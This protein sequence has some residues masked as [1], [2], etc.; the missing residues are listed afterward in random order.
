MK[1]INI[2][3]NSNSQIMKFVLPVNSKNIDVQI[4]FK[5]QQKGWFISFDYEG[6][7]VRSMRI[8]TSGNFLHQYRNLIPFG[9]ACTVENNQEPMLRDDFLSKR[10]ILYLLTQNEVTA[11]SEAISGKATT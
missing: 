1:Q 3:T 5:E 7:S 6:F 9:L 8:V 2:I 11:F 4:F 10:A